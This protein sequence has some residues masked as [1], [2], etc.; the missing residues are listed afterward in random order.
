MRALLLVLLAASG[1]TST[2]REDAGGR[3][4]HTFTVTDTPTGH[5]IHVTREGGG[6]SAVEDFVLDRSWHTVAWTHVDVKRGT[7]VTARRNGATIVLEGKHEGDAVFEEYDAGT[8]PWHQIMPIDLE[9]F[10]RSG[11]ESFRYWAIGITGPGAL[12]MATF[13]ATREGTS[14][15]TVGGKPVD[16]VHVR[17]SLTG[18]LRP[19]WGADYWFRAS[20]GKWL[21]FQGKSTFGEGTIELV[22]VT[23]PG[24]S[25]SPP[26][27]PA[28]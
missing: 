12:K 20:D 25:G 7:R 16:A 27:A 23:A 2:Y 28:P 8:Q 5:A 10:V 4:I 6:Y 19:F 9:P 22:K 18:L 15:V 17:I 14:R 1:S 11:K 13:E 26:P 21:R 24:T 3:S